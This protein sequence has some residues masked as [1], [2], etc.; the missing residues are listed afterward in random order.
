MRN[1]LFAFMLVPFAV[2]LFALP[3]P[4]SHSEIRIRKDLIIGFLEHYNSPEP[5]GFRVRIA[6][7]KDKGLWKAY[8]SDFNTPA[9]LDRALNYFPKEVSWNICFD[10]GKTGS[11][12]SRNPK[13]INRYMD[14]GLQDLDPGSNIP[15]IGE[16][17]LL[18]SGFLY[19]PVYRPLLL[20]SQ[21]YCKDPDL[22]KPYR[23]ENRE[24]R[25]VYDFS[26]EEV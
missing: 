17:S 4:G 9:A 26:E 10:G 11:L 15:T 24:I 13:E 2:F 22:W 23:P 12:R 3:F 14:V 18:F 1:R 5:L 19:S 16:L 8:K 25:L 7:K 20:N 21:P 6:F